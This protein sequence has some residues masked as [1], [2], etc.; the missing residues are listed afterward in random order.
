MDTLAVG[1]LRSRG[2]ENAHDFPE[3]GLDLRTPHD[4]GEMRRADLLFAFSH[5]D[6][7]DRQFLPGATDGMQSRQKRRLGALLINGAASNQHFAEAGFVHHA[8]FPGWRRPLRRVNLLHVV[9]EIEPQCPRRSRI[10]RG[11]DS[12][13][14]VGGNFRDL[15]E[16]CIAKHLHGELATFVH[17]AILRGNRGLLDPRLEPEQGFVMPLGDLRT[18]GAQ[19]IFGGSEPMWSHCARGADVG[20]RSWPGGVKPRGARSGCK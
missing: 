16:A 11:K 5:H 12:G 4:L 14:A 7:V 6:Q 3:R 20:S 9:H 2:H 15:L 1:C 8:R 13:L 19:I 18:Y 17:S 10:E